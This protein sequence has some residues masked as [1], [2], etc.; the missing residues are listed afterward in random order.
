MLRCAQGEGAVVGEVGGR[1]G[2]ST[3]WLCSRVVKSVVHGLGDGHIHRRVMFTSF[4][5]TGVLATGASGSSWSC[6]SCRR[7]RCTRPSMA[8]VTRDTAS[9]GMW[10]PV[11]AY[12][13][14]KASACATAHCA[15]V[16][17]GR[18]TTSSTVEVT[19]ATVSGT[20]AH[21]CS[22]NSM[23]SSGHPSA[24]QCRRA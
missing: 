1:V 3:V 12:Q 18:P 19:L 10:R 21:M 17:G 23:P 5:G 2:S 14:R 4:D 11:P 13:A 7:S 8:N 22:M 6:R 16:R 9:G 24:R 15:K 20:V